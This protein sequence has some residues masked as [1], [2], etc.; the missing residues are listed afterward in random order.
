MSQDKF[1]ASP[2]TRTPDVD[3]WSQLRRLTAARIGL[4]RTG[5]SLATAPL[6]D[7]RLAHAQARDAVH[8]VLDVSALM[9]ALQPLGLPALTLASAAADKHSFLMRPDLGRRLTVESR[10]TLTARATGNAACYDIVFVISDGLS[11]RAVQSHAAPTLRETVPVLAAAGWR[12]APLVIVRH[13][14]VAIG[15]QIA[16]EL[17]ADCVIMLIGER[18]GLSAP[19]S[20]GAYIT[21]R[22]D[23]GT[24]DADRNCI[25]NIRPD[26]IGYN[27]AGFKLVH[28]LQA[29]KARRISGVQ[30]KD[31]SDL[32]AIDP[33]ALNGGQP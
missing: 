8:A 28:M 6:L 30:L 4:P 9:V 1:V 26:G 32:K 21:W 3:L 7:F 15:D 16:G 33:A 22:P 29:I 24:S 20:M 19:D 23:E 14:R 25:S 18:P 12:I 27:E 17:R 10:G 13:G 2:T 5:A 31:E 11:A